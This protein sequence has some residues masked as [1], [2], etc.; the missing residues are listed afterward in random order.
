M[1]E[2]PVRRLARAYSGSQEPHAIERRANWSKRLPMLRT[3][4]APAQRFEMDPSS[5]TNV[6]RETIFR[7]NVV[8]FR[9]ET[10]PDD[11]GKNRSRRHAH[12][13]GVAVDERH[14]WRSV[15]DNE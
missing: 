13:S 1:R 11:L 8:Q 10:I 3:R 4:T 9:H 5:V 15:F 6:S 7:P 12:R 2:H 14:L